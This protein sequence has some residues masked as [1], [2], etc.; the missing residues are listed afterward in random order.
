MKNAHVNSIISNH[1]T[2]KET[3]N[4]EILSVF[5][6]ISHLKL[7]DREVMERLNYKDMNAVRPRIS[8]MIR[9]GILMEVGTI[10]DPLTK[11]KVR[12]V[13]LANKE[14]QLKFL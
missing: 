7:T 3:R 8:E 4:K 13:E 9:K 6:S 10:R 12:F 1:D 5:N 14:K 11:R 2:D